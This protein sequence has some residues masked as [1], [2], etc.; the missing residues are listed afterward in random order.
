MTY[1]NV[2]SVVIIT[3]L[4]ASKAS[5]ILGFRAVL[6]FDRVNDAS[7][8]VEF[9]DG[10]PELFVKDGSVGDDDDAVEYRVVLVVVQRHEPVNQP[11]D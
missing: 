11:R 8:V 5:A 10:V 1:G 3:G 7:L 6:A 9:V 4:P 2:W